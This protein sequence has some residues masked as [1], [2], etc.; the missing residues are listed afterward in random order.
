[1]QEADRGVMARAFSQ[2]GISKLE[3]F[4]VEHC[5][6]A[7]GLQLESGDRWKV[8]FSGDTRPCMNVVQ[9]AKN[10]LILIHE[11]RFVSLSHSA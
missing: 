6:N 9:A 10:A 5:A 1:M 7:Y 11:V 3:S 2:L 4:T 8:V